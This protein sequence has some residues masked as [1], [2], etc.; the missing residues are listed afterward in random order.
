M[1]H[2]VGAGALLALTV[3]SGVLLVRRPRHPV[4]MVLAVMTCG[5]LLGPLA[6]DG[7]SNTLWA[8]AVLPLSPLLIAFPDG[9]RGP[10]WRRVFIGLVVVIAMAA[11]LSSVPAAREGPLFVVVGVL[12]ASVLPVAGAAVISLVR[13]WRHSVG[14][15]R[16]R[17]GIVLVAG[18]ALV[19]PYLTLAPIVGGARALGIET[20]RL[21][22]VSDALSLGLTFSLVPL[23]IGVSMLLEPVGR[24]WRWVE[25]TWPWLFGVGAALLVGGTGVEVGVALGWA[26]GDPVLVAAASVV[27]AGCAAAAG[28]V[29]RRAPSRIPA[30]DDRTTVALRDLA[31][32]LDSVPDADELPAMV[33]STVGRALDLRGVAID[34][35]LDGRNTRLASWGQLDG[36]AVV[37]TLHHAG[38]PVGRLV[39]VPHGDGVPIDLVVLDPLLPSVA[40]TVA[41]TGLLQRLLIAYQHINEVRSGERARLRSDL[42]DE[43]SPSL[44]GVRLTLH[45]ARA[46][47]TRQHAPRGGAGP[48]ATVDDPA[49]TPSVGPV[50]V[51]ALLDRADSEL[52]RAGAVVAGILDDLRPGALVTDGLLAAV[53]A[54][55]AVFDR[56]GRFVVTVDA[57]DALPR[58]SASA[59]VA[60]LRVAGEAVCNAARHSGGSSCRVALRGRAGGLSLM[61]TDDGKGMAEDRPD[62]H[63][64]D[65]MARRVRLAGGS[66]DLST[67]AG[68]GTTLTAWFPADQAGTEQLAHSRSAS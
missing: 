9:P 52:G 12:A 32:R 22:A 54:R 8:M 46:H 31:A 44:A 39:L 24:R 4:S 27:V 47:L 56:P 59:E 10:G 55:A 53:R 68:V 45:A 40:A 66:L 29:L 37:R 41:A 7:L 28:T 65:S 30:A 42:H 17:I 67:S 60:V 3:V 49:I 14:E 61:V 5:A 26:A 13:L 34:L 16:W 63:G 33:A 57:D 48:T 43:L 62:G 11:V 50:D 51:D 35:G 21:D 19:V 38:D 6:P 15:R 36:A 25:R 64:L 58:L 1:Q 20:S 23:A 2:V 18:L